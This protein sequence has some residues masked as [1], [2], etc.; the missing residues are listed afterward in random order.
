MTYGREEFQPSEPLQLI[1]FHIIRT[2][3]KEKIEHLNFRF[4]L[5]LLRLTE[6]AEH[7]QASEP[8]ISSLSSVEVGIHSCLN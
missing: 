3:S 8:E 4:S 1:H 5:A 6:A 7:W 2:A